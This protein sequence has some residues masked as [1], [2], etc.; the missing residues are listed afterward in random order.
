MWEALS[1]R[2]YSSYLSV[3]IFDLMETALM[4]IA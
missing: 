3:V 1:P 2:S 4:S